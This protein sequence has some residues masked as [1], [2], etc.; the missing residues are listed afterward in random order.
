MLTTAAFGVVR[1]FLATFC[2]LVF[3]VFHRWGHFLLSVEYSGY[4]YMYKSLMKQFS[5]REIS[6]G[7]VSFAFVARG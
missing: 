3:V 2:L 5:V 6:P 4:T 1:S 7:C